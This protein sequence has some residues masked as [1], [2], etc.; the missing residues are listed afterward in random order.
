MLKKH[1][2]SF[3]FLGWLTF[4]V[5][6]MPTYGQSQTRDSLQRLLDEAKVALKKSDSVSRSEKQLREGLLLEVDS[7][8]Q[9][10][11]ERATKLEQVIKEIREKLLLTIKSDSGHVKGASPVVVL[12]DTL[13]WIEGAFGPYSPQ[14]RAERIEN[15]LGNLERV[16]LRKD[17]M[18]SLQL[19]HRHYGVDI[20]INE[21]TIHT[22][23][24]DDAR[25]EGME[26]EALAEKQMAIIAEHLRQNK[27]G[28]LLKELPRQLGLS[29]LV[30]FVQVIL[31]VLLNRLF[32]KRI[33]PKLLSL[34]GGLFKGFKFKNFELL[35][36]EKETRLALLFSKAVRYLII[37]VMLF[38]TLPVIF[39]LYPPTK[40]L[41]HQLFGYI[42]NPFK[43]VVSAFVGYIPNLITILVIL[44]VVRQLLKFLKFFAREIELGRL[45]LSWFYPDWAKPTF[46][47]LRAFIY[48][49][50]FVMI[51]PYLPASE[52]PIFKGVS[53]FLGVVFS[54]GSSSVIG[55][56][57]SGLI[58]TY[59]RSFQLGDRIRIG[60][61]FG[62]VVEKTA[63]VTRIRTTKNEYISVPNSN[64]T[65]SHVVNYST[66]KYKSE[67]IILHT[68]VTIGYDVPWKTVHE[69]LIQAA[70]QTKTIRKE[71][72]PFVLQ[73]SLD[74]FYVTYELNA[75]S[76]APHL[77][78]EIYSE[79]HQNI[80]DI[81]NEHEVEIMSPHYR[82]A[83]DGN[84]TTIP[85]KYL[86]EDYRPPSFRFRKDEGGE[87][88]E[89]KN[90]E[91]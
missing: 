39:S 88:D 69:L 84:Q 9:K 71:P 77:Q 30:I 60:E 2:L 31:I 63:F 6:P 19:V 28:M 53:V 24:A 46:N 82:A 18:D 4:L 23:T 72:T 79:L 59:M 36:P 10:D 47:I 12:Q 89:D 65:S 16:F 85:K 26:R 21:K 75:H 38:I 86:P 15:R 50:T 37:G 70:I 83:R 45:K 64:I 78:T 54:I 33:D 66:K 74:D 56:I 35:T 49:I 52:S 80:Q 3:I 32:R 41:A 29:L 40:D 57:V 73:T 8:R 91:G 51:F 61:I 1:L 13:F 11:K 14:E 20:Q 7:L 48:I 5:M 68:K 22:V 87:E 55:N 90:G 67:N 58:I 25:V 81:F 34:E 43:A 76:D 27:G 44:Y 17:I 62:D 42:A